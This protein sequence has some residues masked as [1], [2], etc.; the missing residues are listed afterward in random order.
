VRWINAIVCTDESKIHTTIQFLAFRLS[1]TFVPI[2]DHTFD[3]ISQVRTAENANDGCGLL[4]VGLKEIF[5]AVRG[6]VIENDYAYGRQL[7]VKD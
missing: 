2:P 6:A 1:K 3:I 4:L 5:R 7:L